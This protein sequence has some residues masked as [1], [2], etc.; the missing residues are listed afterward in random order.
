MTPKFQDIQVIEVLHKDLDW[1][2]P[3]GKEYR[4]PFKLSNMAREE[5]VKTFNE[6]CRDVSSDPLRRGASIHLDQ[7]TLLLNEDDDETH[8]VRELKR[9][10]DA[11]NKAYREKLQKRDEAKHAAEERQRKR[12]EKI[13]ELRQKAKNLKI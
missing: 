2:S 10:L 11:T 1:A 4:L 13:E 8:H 12:D 7:L 3:G 6:L 5:W 9:V